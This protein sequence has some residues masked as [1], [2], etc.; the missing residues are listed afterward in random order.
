VFEASNDARLGDAIAIE[1][2]GVL[3]IVDPR[4]FHARFRAS[5]LASLDRHTAR[6][7]WL[8]GALG[9]LALTLL[10]VAMA[11][12]HGLAILVERGHPKI[13]TLAGLTSLSIASAVLYVLWTTGG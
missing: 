12:A 2:A 5:D 13:A 7:A 9:S 4:G 8:A 10:V 3:H 6:F 11:F 1:R